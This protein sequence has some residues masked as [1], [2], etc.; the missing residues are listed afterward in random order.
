[1]G[2]SRT[3]TLPDQVISFSSLDEANLII[4]RKKTKKEQWWPHAERRDL[5]DQQVSSP[6]P[7]H[8]VSLLIYKEKLVPARWVTW[9]PVKSAHSVFQLYLLYKV[10]S[11]AMPSAS[12]G[13]PV[14]DGGS[15]GQQGMNGCSPGTEDH[16]H[17]QMLAEMALVSPP[18]CWMGLAD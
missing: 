12:V 2:L 3:G 5:N 10:T 15:K 13:K 6:S 16:L 1:M 11:G 14:R 4:Q 18:A 8:E 7:Q 17:L 9:R